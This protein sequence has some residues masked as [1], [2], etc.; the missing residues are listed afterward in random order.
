MTVTRNLKKPLHI[1]I[2]LIFGIFHFSFSQKTEVEKYYIRVDTSF[3]SKL[4]KAYQTSTEE[5]IK[6]L[7]VKNEKRENLGFGYQLKVSGK[8]LG[9]ISIDYQILYFKNEIVSYKLSTHIP[10]KAKRLKKLYKERLSEIF[11][12]TGDY[13]V[14]PIYFGL[15]KANEPL[16]G[17]DKMTENNLNG[18]MNPFIGTFYGNYCGSGMH[19]MNNRKVFDEIIDIENCEYLIYSKNPATRLMAVEF[20]Y[21]N[22]SQFRDEQKKSIELRIKELKRKPMLT[23]TCHGS[24][25]GGELTEKIITRLKNCR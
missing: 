11:E 22:L 8:G 21:C 17:I 9:S 24:F 15:E 3:V 23:R 10:N 13:K 2:I 16:T 6:V 7:E 20:Y 12:V 19:L 18:I 25:A 4:K 14:K 5:L 1:S